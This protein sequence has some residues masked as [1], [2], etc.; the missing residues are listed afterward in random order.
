MLGLNEV[1]QPHKESNMAVSQKLADHLRKHAV[2]NIHGKAIAELKAKA[3]KAEAE[4]HKMPYVAID[5]AVY[6]NLRARVGDEN[7][8]W[9]EPNF[10]RTEIKIESFTDYSQPIDP[11]TGQ[12]P[13]IEKPDMWYGWEGGTFKFRGK[14]AGFNADW[15]KKEEHTSAYGR[16]GF[17][18][19]NG[20][21]R[22][23]VGGHNGSSKEQ[24]K[25][26]ATGNHRYGDIATAIH[27]QAERWLIAAQ[28]EARRIQ[29]RSTAQQIHDMLDQPHKQYNGVTIGSSASAA[30]PILLRI[31]VTRSLTL[32]AAA[33]ILNVLKKHN[34]G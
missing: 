26:Q 24:F 25:Q 33:E 18:K 4:G 13:T 29:N 15:Y 14:Y 27:R 6:D 2:N 30:T 12:R 21:V 19:R 8:E 16:Q 1:I 3:D 28:D 34:I 31:D 20:K 17:G 7:I 5:R 11:V 22:I 23:Y 9:I 32:E 10:R